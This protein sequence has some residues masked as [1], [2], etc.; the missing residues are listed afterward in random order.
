M[1]C[2]TSSAT[3]CICE[4]PY[5]SLVGWA[6]S[7]R[8]GRRTFGAFDPLRIKATVDVDRGS[9]WQLSC[10]LDEIEVPKRSPLAADVGVG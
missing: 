7:H 9:F 10:A 2:V 1:C 4:G 3:H 6:P 5:P 8:G